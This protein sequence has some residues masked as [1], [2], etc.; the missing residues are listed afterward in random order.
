[1]TFFFVLSY[2][3]LLVEALSFFT[4]LFYLFAHPG[5]VLNLGRLATVT[6]LILPVSHTSHELPRVNQPPYLLAFPRT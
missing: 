4:L 5:R 3:H 2:S 1:V 6:R